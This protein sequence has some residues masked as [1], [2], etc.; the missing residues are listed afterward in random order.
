[1]YRLH[2]THVRYL[3]IVF[4]ISVHWMFWVGIV[5]DWL[6]GPVFFS[7]RKT[8]RW[9][10]SKFFG[11]ITTWVS[12]RHTIGD[13]KCNVVI[14]TYQDRSLMACSI[15]G[16]KYLGFFVWCHLKSSVTTPVK[17]TGLTNQIVHGCDSVRDSNLKNFLFFIF[18]GIF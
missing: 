4:S 13:E 7:I 9:G 5:G 2:K 16:L 14:A 10:V 17:K 3:K 1:M 15:L 8:Y 12:R 11:I 18:Q 6:I